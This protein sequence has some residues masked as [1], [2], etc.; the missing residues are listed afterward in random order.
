MIQCFILR[1]S[2]SHN[3]IPF[4]NHRQWGARCIFLQYHIINDHLSVYDDVCCKS[5]TIRGSISSPRCWSWW[6]QSSNQG[7]CKI[8]AN[9]VAWSEK[10]GKLFRLFE[11]TKKI[12]K[13]VKQWNMMN[14]QFWSLDIHWETLYIDVL[15]IVNLTETTD[16]ASVVS[17]CGCLPLK[18]TSFLAGTLQC[19]D[20]LRCRSMCS[21]PPIS[22]LDGGFF[23]DVLCK[24]LKVSIETR[25]FA[26]IP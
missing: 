14:A 4:R 22:L 12:E 8:P 2:N 16:L 3:S 9:P 1:Q 18:M 6:V 20:M 5:A 15:L 23:P 17:L 25:C 13:W 19:S 24:I 10:P 11:N 26:R 21:L 7:V